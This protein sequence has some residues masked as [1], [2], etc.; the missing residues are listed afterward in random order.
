LC[1]PDEDDWGPEVTSA[2]IRLAEG[3]RDADVLW[4]V[5]NALSFAGDPRGLPTLVALAGHADRDVRHQAAMALPSCEEGSDADLLACA[6]IGL[7]GDPDEDVRDWATFGL[8][9][10]TGIDGPDVREALFSRLGDENIEV[11]DEALVGLARRHDRRMVAVVAARLDQEEVG[12]LAVEAASYVADE[13]LTGP[14]RALRSWWDVDRELLDDALAACDPERQARDVE[15]QTAFL[16]LLEPALGG[17][18]GVT[19][20]LSCERLEREVSVVIER[21]GQRGLDDFRGLVADRAGGDL[22]VAVH[23]VLSDLARTDGLAA[24]RSASG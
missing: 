17:W 16:A 4:S 7:M 11:R 5:A 20:T 3:E 10:Q 9:T 15:E 22:A 6:L 2:V 23:A 18:P 19:A 24:A 12:R 1:N 14:L 13:R 21:N 8:G